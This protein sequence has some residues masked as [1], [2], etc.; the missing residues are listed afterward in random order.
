MSVPRPLRFSRRHVLE[1]LGGLA[2]S[3]ALL[4]CGAIDGLTDGGTATGGGG[5]SVATGGGGGGSTAAWATAGT[6]VL[7]GKDYG[8]PFASG[9]GTACRLFKASTEGPCHATSPLLTRRDVSEGYAGLPMRLELVVVNANCTPVPNAIVEIWHCDTTG[10]YSGDIDGTN[11]AMCTGG[12]ATAAAALWYRG[13][14][15]ADANGRVTFDSNF[16]GWYASRATHIHFR[17]TLSTTQYVVSQLFF[18]EALKSEIYNSQ[19]NYRA[20]SNQGYQLNASDKVVS[21]AG[22]TLADVVVSTAKQSD[23]ALLAWKALA[24]SA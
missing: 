2:G 3:M 6:S 23:G 22:L 5:G 17:V 12:K 19:P 7:S 4:R 21:E 11:D 8:N 14:Q 18:D 24:I 1:T 16:P 20:T 15:T 9:L 10:T 13:I